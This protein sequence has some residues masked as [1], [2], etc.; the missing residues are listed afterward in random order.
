MKSSSTPRNAKGQFK[1]KPG[2]TSKRRRTVKDNPTPAFP[3]DLAVLNPTPAGLGQIAKVGAGVAAG[4]FAGKSAALY[5][6]Q[7]GMVGELIQVAAPIALGY[8]VS[9]LGA[10]NVGSGLMAAGAASAVLLGASR[11]LKLTKGTKEGG[12]E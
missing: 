7:T 8:G 6:K 5:S 11:L 1:R 9:K 3:L 10:P 12:I 4:M 2:S